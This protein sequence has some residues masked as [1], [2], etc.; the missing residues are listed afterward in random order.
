MM[1]EKVPIGLKGYKNRRDIVFSQA[2][3]LHSQSIVATSGYSAVST[4]G[5]HSQSIVATS[6][7]SAVCHFIHWVYIVALCMFLN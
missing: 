5:L 6:G 3:G 2:V 1:T 7:C 4:L